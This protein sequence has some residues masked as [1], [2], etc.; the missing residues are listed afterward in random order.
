ML[1]VTR[2]SEACNNYWDAFFTRSR[3]IRSRLFGLIEPLKR[4]MHVRFIG[5]ADI[6][7]MDRVFPKTEKKR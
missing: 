7:G 2:R 1:I 4:V 3:I 6:I 5:L